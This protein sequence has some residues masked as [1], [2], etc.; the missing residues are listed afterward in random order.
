MNL[1]SDDHNDAPGRGWEFSAIVGLL[2]ELLML[3]TDR[4]SSGRATGTFKRGGDTVGGAMV[5]AATDGAA[6]C[7]WG[8]D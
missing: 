6:D 1:P 2:A 5:A 7:A 3:A 4:G 8:A